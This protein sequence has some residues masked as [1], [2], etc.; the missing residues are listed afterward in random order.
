[1]RRPRVPPARPRATAPAAGARAVAA[2]REDALR[3][4]ANLLRAPLSAIS[5][6]ATSLASAAADPVSRARAAALLE[7]HA[8]SV[9]TLADLE[10]LAALEAS[11]ATLPLDPCAPA[12]L[13]AGAA[14]RV[15]AAAD[16]AGVSLVVA[17]PSVPALRCDPAR[18]ELALEVILRRAVRT[19]GRGATVTLR[20]APTGAVIRFTVEGGQPGGEEAREQLAQDVWSARLA[21]GVPELLG[22]ALARVVA[23]AHG[24]RIVVD[25]EPAVL[26]VEV[27]LTP[28]PAG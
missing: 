14:R 13:A 24:G 10:E 3:L 15:A 1:V 17:A 26:H 18:L 8:A 27:P 11:R 20:A 12:D 5:I 2:A 28:P 21:R 4:A 22:L 7:A 16:H 19:A 9:Q 23:E 6:N 25:P